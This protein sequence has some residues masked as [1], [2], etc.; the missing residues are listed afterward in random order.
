DSNKNI[1]LKSI[2][3]SAEEDFFLKPWHSVFAALGD[4]I[5]SEKVYISAQQEEIISYIFPSFNKNI[6]FKK[7]DII[8]QNENTMFEMAV[9]AIIQLL[10]KITERKK[11][12]FVFDDIQWMDKMSKLLLTKILTHFSNKNVLLI[13]AYRND[14]ESKMLSFTIPLIKSDL[15]KKIMLNRFSFEETKNIV[16]EYLPNVKINDF[17]LNNIYNDTEGNALFLIELLKVVK[18]KGYTKELSS[19]ATNI[20]NSRIMDLS[21]NEKILLNNISLFFD[22]VSIDCLKILVPFDEL[23]IFDLIESLQEKNLIC[24]LITDKDIFYSFTH[25]KIREYIYD[26]QSNGK[27]ILL[28]EK[29]GNYFEEKFKSSGKKHLYPNLIYHFEKCGNKYKSL[30]YKVEN[31]TDLY[32]MYHETYPVYT[33]DTIVYNESKDIFNVEAKLNEINEELCL[34][35]KTDTEYL[36]IKMEFSYLLG[37][38]YISMGVYDKGLENIDFSLRLADKLENYIYL[39]NNYKQ[40]VFYSIQVNDI[41]IMFKYINK[42]LKLLSLYD[43]IEERGTM[44]RLKGL[45]YIKIKKYEEAEK[46]LNESINI[47]STLNNI[48]NK[49]I[50]SISASYNYLGQLNINLGQ[51]DLAI[52]YY[53]KA[54]NLCNENGISKGL[55]I[56]YS[57]IGQVLC[58]MKNFDEAK[59]YMINS[60]ELFKKYESTWGRDLAECYMTIILIN[61]KNIE[62][63]KIHFSL[64]Q[65]FATKLNNPKTLKLVEDIKKLLK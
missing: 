57:N 52:D 23:E 47:F 45:Y 10:Q 30:K 32:T 11:I 49:Y 37:R 16:S 18:D 50:L 46:L 20:I 40:M 13:G 53:K 8:N 33:S 27:K 39:L 41:P 3:Y 51:F 22:K 36:K 65:E 59:K 24:E 2:C 5:K 31:L 44:L 4:Y 28:H 17:L 64:A 29:I 7:S 56:F 6:N 43:N 25:Q 9:D 21:K 48:S 42:S 34:L 15:L 63:A 35:D 26:N 58:E 1:I 62:E 61:K 19:K 38:Y 54:I 55:E 60:L 14:F 12:I